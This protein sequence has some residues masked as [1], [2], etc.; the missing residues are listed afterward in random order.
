[1]FYIHWKTS[2]SSFLSSFLSVFFFCSKLHHSIQLCFNFSKVTE[3]TDIR[4]PHGIFTTS[5]KKCLRPKYTIYKHKSDKSKKFLYVSHFGILSV[6]VFHL[7]SVICRHLP[8]F[9]SSTAYTSLCRGLKYLLKIQYFIKDYPDFYIHFVWTGKKE[10]P[11]SDK[12]S[13]KLT[14]FV[15]GK[16]YLHQNFTECMFNQCTFFF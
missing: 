13:Q 14:A 12:L 15:F 1:M 3:M 2:I 11:I 6:I 16:K 10:C 8:I 4:E 5:R 9:S 7:S